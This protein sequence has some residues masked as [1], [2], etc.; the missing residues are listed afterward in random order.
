MK[1]VALAEKVFEE[2]IM[3]SDTMSPN[4]DIY[5]GTVL[6]KLCEL[7]QI[8][9]KRIERIQIYYRGR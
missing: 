4:N 2:T 5:F 3:L 6:E 7:M 8:E 1:R 9:L